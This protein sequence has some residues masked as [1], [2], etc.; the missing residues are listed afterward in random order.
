[1]IDRTPKPC[2][3]PRARHTHGT[4]I[5]YLRDACRC[6]PCAKANSDYERTRQRRIAYGTWAPL[7]DAE[8]ARAHVRALMAQGV[9]HKRIAREAG[10]NHGHVGRLLYGQPHRGQGPS[11]RISPE[12]SAALLA[13][14]P[15]PCLAD[16][17][18]TVRRARALF[19]AGYTQTFLARRLGL[20]VGGF[21]AVAWGRNRVEV[22]LSTAD[23]I[24]E[25]YE[26]LADKTPPETQSARRAR[27]MATR[28]GWAPPICWDDDTIDDPLAEPNWTGFDETLVQDWLTNYQAPPGC[29][30]EE[31]TEVIRR[32][33]AH[34]FTVRQ[35]TV[36]TGLGKDEVQGMRNFI[37]QTER[38]RGIR[39]RVNKE[40]AA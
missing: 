14:R 5:A 9:G 20:T 32:L 17:T 35:M 19:A 15:E 39:R 6:A 21:N 36:L 10:L 11:K 31:L 40:R 27:T 2:T 37:T 13:V 8:P 24:A 22:R 3:H 30:P 23:R 34:E 38:E 4:R 25:L 33:M 16:P 7:V 18:G 28:N 26:D 1:M 12:V 29:G